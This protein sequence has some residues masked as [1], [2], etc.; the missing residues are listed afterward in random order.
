MSARRAREA[1]VAVIRPA[2]PRTPFQTVAGA[3]ERRL[4]GAL[5]VPIEQVEP[6][7]GQPRRD[8][9]YDEGERR[10]DELAASIREFGI[11]QPLVV[12]EDGALTDGRQRYVIIAGARRRIAGERAGLA[13][14]PVI[15]RGEEATQ[16]RLLQLIENLQRHDLSPLDEAR[17]YQELMDAEGLSSPLLANRLH[18]SAQHVRDRLRVLGDQILADAV[19]RRQIAAATA[20]SITQLPDEEREALRTRVA[21]GETV[22]LGDVAAIR[23]QLAAT[24]LANP[25]RK[26]RGREKQTVFV[27]ALPRGEG[28]SDGAATLPSPVPLGGSRGSERTPT[29]C[30]WANSAIAMA[31]LLAESLID[32]RRAFVKQSLARMASEEDLAEWWMS[33]YERLRD[34]LT[35]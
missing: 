26:G 21:R 11:L 23:G 4:P 32:E 7:P 33:V 8:W 34:L 2:Q 5:E 16:V 20:R 3:T 25:R 31:T 22:Q 14:V 15:V 29:Y 13:A 35:E 17:A 18:V 9:A 28:T 30:R 24:G 6:D 1:E 19:E 27:S 10:I 12:R